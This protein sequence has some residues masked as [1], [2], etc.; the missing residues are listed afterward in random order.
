[1]EIGLLMWC[2][3]GKYVPIDIQIQQRNQFWE[4]IGTGISYILNYVRLQEVTKYLL[5]ITSK[6]KVPV[7]IYKNPHFMCAK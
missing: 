2:L 5:L 4:K 7:N 6:W 3:F 1:M